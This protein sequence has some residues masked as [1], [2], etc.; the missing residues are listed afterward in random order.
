MAGAHASV[1]DRSSGSYVYSYLHWTLPLTTFRGKFCFLGICIA[2]GSDYD[3][4]AYFGVLDLLK[5]WEV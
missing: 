2:I 4:D 1:E 5:N 3:F